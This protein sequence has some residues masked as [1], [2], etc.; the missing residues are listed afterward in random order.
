M[1]QAET[2][3]EL[4]QGNHLLG[5]KEDKRPSRQRFWL[6][7]LISLAVVGMAVFF[8]ARHIMN[9]VAL[10]KNTIAWALV[11]GGQNLP[12]TYPQVWRTSAAG[13]RLPLILGLVKDDRGWI[14]YATTNRWNAGGDSL[15]NQIGPLVIFSD[16]NLAEVER[17]D[18]E[19][20]WT[21]AL[22]LFRH[23]AFAVADLKYLD[24][25]FDSKIMGP[26][27]ADGWQTDLHLTDSPVESPTDKDAS[28]N[29]D[30]WPQAWPSINQELGQRLN[31]VG[32]AERPTYISWNAST[33]TQA[34][35]DLGYAQ[36]PAT[37]TIYNLAGA[38]GLSDEKSME[39]PDGSSLM[40][41]RWPINQLE[42]RGFGQ[43]SSGITIIRLGQDNIILN[44]Q[45]VNIPDPKCSKGTTTAYFSAAIPSQL[46]GIGFFDA[47]PNGLYLI[48]QNGFL[49]LCW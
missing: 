6:F 18:N 44:P 26:I 5:F 40:E 3:I 7:G 43:V 32:I 22:S 39:L 10:P 21:A 48:N 30:V 12:D 13:T 38:L 29:L 19:T 20:L 15:R 35:I 16:R 11:R 4:P 34:L 14:P 33:D 9:S 45:T 8:F 49:K 27:D 36:A 41:L 47:L 31:G 37:S 2:I 23:Q 42:G 24:P 25:S 1:G 46:T 28:I 17:L